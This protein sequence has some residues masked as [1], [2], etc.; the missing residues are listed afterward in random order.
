MDSLHRL[1]LNW[2][3]QKKENVIL[4]GRTNVGKSLVF[5]SFL[6][7]DKS[8]PLVKSTVS[9]VHG[10]TMGILR[11]KLANVRNPMGLKIPKDLYL[12]DLPGFFMPGSSQYFTAEELDQTQIV[13]RIKPERHSLTSSHVG[14]IGGFCRIDVDSDEPITFQLH[15]RSSVAYFK[16]PIKTVDRFI[17]DHQGRTHVTPYMAPPFLDEGSSRDLT[18]MSMVEFEIP[19]SLDSRRIALD[20]VFE[21]GLGWISFIHPSAAPSRVRISTPGGLGVKLRNPP[22]RQFKLT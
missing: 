7:K 6:N 13:S 21:D 3:A 2:A 12:L 8:L 11:K 5:N 17:A 14:L 20:A 4:M 9:A 10:T 1:I 19:P 15:M 16:K 18:L 22:L